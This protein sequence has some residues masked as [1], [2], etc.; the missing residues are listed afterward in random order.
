MNTRSAIPRLTVV[1]YIMGILQIIGGVIL[2]AK[3]LP[4]ESDLGYRLLFSA[5]APALTWLLAGIISGMLV[6]AAADVYMHLKGL[7]SIQR[8]LKN[9]EDDISSRSSD[10]Q[11]AL[12][13]IEEQLKANRKE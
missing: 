6:L 3:L 7:G 10:L 1:L 13:R 2:C 5:Y 9:L 11:K 12:E 4:G 8:R